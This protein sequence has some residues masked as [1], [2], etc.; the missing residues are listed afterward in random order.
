ME[1]YS[2]IGAQ[3]AHEVF[4]EKG[5]SSDNNFDPMVF[6]G[7]EGV[8]AIRSQQIILRDYGVDIPL[9]QL[10]EY[11]IANGWYD[12]D[13]VNGGTPMGYIGCLLQSC[14][15][16][17]HQEINATVYDLVNELAQGHRVIVSVDA[18]ELWADR[19]GNIIEQ[20]KTYF[21]DIFKGKEANHALVVAGVDV[22]PDDPK[23]VKVILT[24]PGTGDLRIEYSLDEFMD[25]WDDSNCFMCTTDSPAPLQYDAASGSMVPS[26]FAYQQYVDANTI[27]LQPDAIY[28]M[29]AVASAH[30]QEGHLDSVGHD[31]DG[32][33]IDY[34]TYSD[35]YSK[36]KQAIGNPLSL[37]IDHFDKNEF[38]SAMRNLFVGDSKSNFVHEPEPSPNPDPI[39]D[40]DDDPHSDPDGDNA[41]IDCDDVDDDDDDVDDVF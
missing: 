38:V 1:D 15:I 37:G 2:K 34:E 17:C 4:G 26:N 9:E 12:P 33:E 35:N 31:N 25:A 41:D 22:N 20:A 32:S 5:N 19:E 29:P 11:A 28:P 36:Y 13:P 30:Y 6:Q 8:C 16:D 14:G 40:P 10:K 24:D 3:A 39:S 7:P 18:N 23:D 27:P 21:E